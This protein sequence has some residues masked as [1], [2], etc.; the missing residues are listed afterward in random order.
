[1]GECVL[2]A[3]H[4]IHTAERYCVVI[5]S[6]IGS[7]CVSSARGGGHFLELPVFLEWMS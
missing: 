1:M 5:G 3:Q 4:H 6:T 2:D 7:I